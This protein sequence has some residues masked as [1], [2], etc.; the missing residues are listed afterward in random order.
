MLDPLPLVPFNSEEQ[1]TQIEE[2]EAR[3]GIR[4]I[5]P[6]SKAGH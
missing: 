3:A 6:L 5:F 4:F 2:T 1:A